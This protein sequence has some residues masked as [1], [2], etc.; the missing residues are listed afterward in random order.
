MLGHNVFISH[1]SQS[2]SCDP[3]EGHKDA[4]ESQRMVLKNNNKNKKIKC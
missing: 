2:D 3:N 1:S 4:Q